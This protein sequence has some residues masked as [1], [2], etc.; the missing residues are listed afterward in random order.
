MTTILLLWCYSVN[1]AE[2]DTEEALNDLLVTFNL[3]SYVSC[4]L[5]EVFCFP[6]A[7]RASN[8]KVVQ[9]YC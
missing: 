1:Q 8:L 6:T 9:T 5:V 7:H 2:R 3:C 4:P